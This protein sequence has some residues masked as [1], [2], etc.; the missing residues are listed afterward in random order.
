MLLNH[1]LWHR[2]IFN[3]HLCNR[4]NCLLRSDL[5]IIPKNPLIL[6]ATGREQL[7][8]LCRQGLPGL[9]PAIRRHSKRSALAK[10]GLIIFSFSCF[11]NTRLPF[12]NRCLM[13]II[14][15]T[16]NMFTVVHGYEEEI[17]ALTR[18]LHRLELPDRARNWARWG[19]YACR[20]CRG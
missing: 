17:A 16:E 18:T 1:R 11:E 19:L 20:C 3:P 13:A 14:G 7:E 2:R 5:Q 8:R 10:T 4:L 12:L 6:G 15:R 9:R